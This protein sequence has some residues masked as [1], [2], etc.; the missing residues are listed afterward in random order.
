MSDQLRGLE[1]E[2]DQI[3]RSI[4]TITSEPFFKRE[5][6]ESTLKRI[7]DLEE[8]VLEKERQARALKDEETR[9]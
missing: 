4:R 1:Q 7:A 5:K 2:R 3:E 9:K 8:R 6:G